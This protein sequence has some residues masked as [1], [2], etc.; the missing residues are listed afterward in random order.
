VR[1]LSADE[2]TCVA[3]GEGDIVIV[4]L[5][6]YLDYQ[7]DPSDP[8]A[9]YRNGG[10]SG[11]WN[12][13]YLAYL[14]S[15]AVTWANAGNPADVDYFGV[16]A[17]TASNVAQFETEISDIDNGLD[18]HAP[19]TLKVGDLGSISLKEI[20][21]IF[22]N[23]DF[24]I[25]EN[26][27]YPDGYGGQTDIDPSGGYYSNMDKATLNGYALHG[28]AGLNLLVLHEIAHN[29]TVMQQ[30]ENN[31]YQTYLLLNNGSPT[32]WADSHLFRD[33]ERTAN[34]IAKS[35]ATQLSMPVMAAPP[36]GY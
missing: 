15:M 27:S 13:Y 21:Q 30:L 25:T 18:N 8:Y 1:Y 6:P 7:P 19:F 10:T 11:D 9:G 24:T 23:M 33:V 12:Q 14:G 34:A 3:G 36:H 20:Q 22:H 5:K 2:L 26:V 4:G 29:T 35:I 31:N 17:V 28:E 32:G 16:D